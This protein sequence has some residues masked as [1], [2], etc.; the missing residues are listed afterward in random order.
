VRHRRLVSLVAALAF[1]AGSLVGASP[2]VAVTNPAVTKLYA[3][4]VHWRHCYTGL[5]CT[6]VKAPV[7]W[8][9]PGGKRISLALVKHRSTGTHH[10]TLFF[11]PGGPGESAVDFLAQD[12]EDIVDATVEADYDVVAFDPRGVGHSTPVRCYGAAKLDQY[13]Y[14]VVPG[15]IGSNDWIDRQRVRAAGFADA[16]AAKTGPLLGH[17]DTTSIA[18]DLDLERAV[19]GQK[20]L[21]F[22]GYSWGTYLGTLYAG[23]FPGRVGRM[24][25]D[26]AY[27]PWESGGSGDAGYDTSQ[28][29]GFE[30]SLRAYL[31][32]CLAGDPQAT[33]A[34]KCAF[35]DADA[36][37]GMKSV[38]ALLRS[39]DKHP[40]R[41]SD[42]RRLGAATLAVA[43]DDDLYDP[44][45]WADLNELFA[46]VKKGDAS[47]AFRASDD[48]NDRSDDGT[49]YDNSAE[50]F[51]ANT[52]LENGADDD[53]ADMRD[54]AAALK[55]A[56]PV[57][58]IYDAYSDITCGA[59]PYGPVDFPDP[60]EA[61]GSPPIMVVGTTH[62]PATPYA[63][64]KALVHQLDNAFLVTY[65]GEGHTAYDKGIACIDATVDAFLLAGTVPPHDPRCT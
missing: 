5:F 61:V 6:T 27:D 59:W 58:G 43:I 10:G 63:G 3:Q 23:L 44:S 4:K 24:V 60:V 35:H 39:V 11:N 28:E 2:A 51:I 62:D 50:Y 26:G 47:T 21:D 20:K 19:L 53:V 38:A 12:I 36:S 37:A 30:H 16:C 31:T 7:D 54:Y 52:C 1:V 14:G 17:I 41:N 49:Y 65:R 13:L 42:G 57:L 55:K 64:A 40:I 25:L 32:G 18:R 9:D 56:A 46:R 29:E 45:E 33:G 48:Y 34:R 8:A 22:L 15:T